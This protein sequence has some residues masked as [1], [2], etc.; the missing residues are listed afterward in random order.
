MTTISK[1]S[2]VFAMELCDAL[3][4]E[5]GNEGWECEAVLHPSTE[6][7]DVGLKAYGE[8]GITVLIEVELRRGNPVVNIIKIWDWAAKY[9]NKKPILLIHA[10]SHYY[11]TKTRWTEYV[12][13]VSAKMCEDKQVNIRY[14]PMPFEFR[15]RK[16]TYG[17]GGAGKAHARALAKHIA[18][19]LP[20]RACAVTNAR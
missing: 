3:K 7:V 18:D 1:K 20:V 8:R 9:S 15:P 13:F 14:K 6:R 2:A 19:C 10:L 5:T 12:S 17:I 16:G 11:C 4:K